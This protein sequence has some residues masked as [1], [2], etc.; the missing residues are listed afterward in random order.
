MQDKAKKE[1]ILKNEAE[2]VPKMINDE[3][4][5]LTGG[6]LMSNLM[7]MEQGKVFDSHKDTLGSMIREGAR[8]ISTAAQKKH[9]VEERRR[10]SFLSNIFH[11]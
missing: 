10:S 11:K 1:G 2:E 4:F 5:A 9:S 7:E 6:D 8:L 3:S